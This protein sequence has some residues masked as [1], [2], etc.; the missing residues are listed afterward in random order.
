M[1]NSNSRGPKASV[2]FDVARLKKARI[3]AG[4]LQTELARNAI[5]DVAT[6]GRAEGGAPVSLDTALGIASALSKSL[7]YLKGEG[8]GEH[9]DPPDARPLPAKSVEQAGF[10]FFPDRTSLNRL[11]DPSAALQSATEVKL[12]VVGGTK[13]IES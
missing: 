1:T 8:D 9:V 13:F 6:V 5:I 2:I 7:G 12:V 10:K 11:R 3:D 4:L